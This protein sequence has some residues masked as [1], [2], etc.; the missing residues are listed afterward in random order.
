MEKY[1][2]LD[3]IGEGSFGRVYKGRRKYS[4]EVVAL[5]F[6]PKVGRSDKELRG[7]KREIQIMKDLQHPNIVRMLDSCE[8]EREVVVVTE[9]AEGEL[10]QIL[11]DD[12]NLS[13]DLVRDVSTQLVSALYYLHSH[14]IL[15]RD[16]KP[17]NILLGKDG[18]V[19]LCDFGFARELSLDTLMVRSI[20]GT[21]LYM[22]PELV[23]ER[24][25]DHRSDLWALGCIVYELLVGTPPFYTHSIFQLVS[26]ITQQPVRWP[27]GVSAE[28]KDFLQ[29]LL[30]KDPALRLSWPGLL[31]HPFIK[32][33]VVVL[34]DGPA[35]SPFTSPLTDE[36]RQLRDRQCDRSG[37]DSVHSRILNRARQRVA[38]R[39]ESQS[40]RPASAQTG[41]EEII[42]HE[43][44]PK[45][46]ENEE[47]RTSQTSTRNH[48]CQDC[49]QD[50]CQNKRERRS[51]ESVCLEN[52]D[53][54]DEW[55]VLLEATD[56]SLA[57]LST[58]FLLL[59]DP[60]FRNRV[61]RRLRDCCPQVSLEAVS[62]LRPALR[63]TCNLLS[64]GCD[65]QLLSDLCV[66]L[67]I[68]HFLLQLI[69]QSLENNVR[70]CS[71]AV[72][73]LT[74]LFALL[75]S[76][77]CFWR[78]PES[79]RALLACT[80]DFLQVLHRLL[81][82]PPAAE[83]VLLERCLQCLVSLSESTSS[84]R[85]AA[86]AQLCQ[87]LLSMYI[88]ALDKIIERSQP[89]APDMVHTEDIGGCSSLLFTRV[90][91]ALCDVPGSAEH[92]LLREKISL[93]VSEQ[94]L[95]DSGAPLSRFVTGL[96][97][98]S[99][100]LSQ[101]KVLYACCHAS[102]EVCQRLAKDKSALQDIISFFEG[103]VHLWD[104]SRVHA[105]ELSLLI[106]A[107]LALRLQSLP[108]EVLGSS[109]SLCHLLT[110]DVPSLVAAAIILAVSLHDGGNPI[111]LSRD[112][113]LSA[114][115]RSLSQSPLMLWSAPMGSG[116]YDW[117]FH[118]LLQQVNQDSQLFPV[119]A[120]EGAFLWRSV[121]ILL[122]FSSLRAPLEGDTPR[123]DE[124]LMPQWR[125][126]SARGLVTFLHLALIT[127]VQ[128]P[129][130]FLG[131]IGCPGSLVLAALT[132]I[133]HPGFLGHV[134]D[135]CQLSGWEVPQTL[136]DVVNVV[137]QLLCVPLSLDISTENISEILKALRQQDVVS[138]LLQVCPLLPEGQ[139]ETPLCL[140]SRLVLMEEQ[141]LSQF[142]S[143]A[144]SSE[145]VVSWLRRSV[146]SGPDCVVIELFT[147]FSHLIR[148]SPTNSLLVGRIVGDWDQL[149]C[150][151]LQTP[152][153]EMRSA[154]CSFA[155]NLSR[156]GE[157]LSASVAENLVNCLSAA[158]GRVRRS[159]AFAVGNCIFHKSFTE[160][161]GSWVSF[162][163]S[164]LLMLLRDP[165]AKTRSHAAAA[166]GNLGS[167]SGDGAD[168]PACL[169]EVPQSLLHAACTDQE[170][171]VRLASVIA[172]RSL[173]GRSN[174]RQQLRAL[175]AGAKLSASL[176]D[177]KRSSPRALP[178]THHCHRLLQQMACDPGT[179]AAPLT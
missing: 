123:E 66:D 158:D 114:V 99:F 60:N 105:A 39:K 29:G 5:K 42:N 106:I 179:D 135:V 170:E 9:Y 115:R 81:C 37:Q 159:A 63:V 16:M 15:H 68:P 50:F 119:V 131:L 124:F 103:E 172:L 120:D 31:T 27:R 13:E 139:V 75:N 73:F 87:S 85:P 10:F 78:L 46:T 11:E 89:S 156:L 118:L 97:H 72:S 8:T 57:H 154:A 112:V 33:K 94:L 132:Q 17:Q 35:S 18:T 153:A 98:S 55:S 130:H 146:W 117:T 21:P 138:S 150:H 38:K 162:A 51:I 136:L 71:W 61:H 160:D 140:V 116:V 47:L 86:C 109:E 147:L 36:Q 128:D 92:R 176:T 40:V 90:L 133:V 4:G 111:V 143:T 174:I 45:M 129:N 155:G 125:L 64:S 142:S 104:A 102:L 175:N 62:R 177:D 100:V 34:E 2:V 166:L 20:K 165:Q 173:S 19:K 41:T 127:S 56:P 161:R 91:A 151:H 79:S 48:P 82:C 84:G 77:Y 1:H 53:S 59:K 49:E 3:L 167:L 58:P 121:C 74:E 145:A 101:L 144:S 44:N 107:L 43:M 148:A 152:D 65:P 168:L 122:R 6:I 96:A 32:D 23:L 171:S 24:P 7:L 113:L 12:G 67:Q 126:L 88:S 163:A 14:R 95:S 134:T 30:T 110:C 80:D 26:I 137:S 83:D 76:Y 169:V 69:N 25:Y 52:E 149:L 157:S 93:Y 141:L 54:D 164:Q 70:Q 22:S 28:L 178:L 108:D